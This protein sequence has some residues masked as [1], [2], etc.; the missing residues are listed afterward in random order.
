MKLLFWVHVGVL[1]IVLA[2]YLRAGTHPSVLTPSFHENATHILATLN[3]IT[4]S[5]YFR[6]FKT[7]SEKPCPYWAV[8]LLCSSENNCHVWKCNSDEVPR[9]LQSA[10]DMSDLNTPPTSKITQRFSHPSNADEW[11]SWINLDASDGSEYIDLVHNPEANTGYS[12]PQAADVWK[13]IYQE[14][15]L[16]LEENQGCKG[17]SLPRLLF[18]GLHTS[19]IIHVATNFYKD[20]YFSSPHLAAGLYNT[21]N[22]SYLP[23]CELFNSKIAPQKEFLQN[24]RLLSEFVFK[25][26]S[27]SEESFLSD[28]SVYNSGNDGTEREEDAELKANLMTLFSSP[29]IKT[30]IFDDHGFLD[31]LR[32]DSMEQ[33]HTMLS[34]VSTIMDCV[35]CEKCRV[36]GKLETKGLVTAMEVVSGAA[37]F[38][39]RAQRVTLVNLARQVYFSIRSVQ[40]MSV[41]CQTNTRE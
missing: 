15:C 24:L 21:P 17:A 19:I 6:Y 2:F 37:T 4:A 18:S 40:H 1:L 20:P 41:I 7:N 23:N 25:A 9:S 28:L 10:F 3:S 14:N 16:P 8:S 22:I 34:N 38:L 36:W 30:P 12:G 5:P 33:I 29:S 27:L 26:I 32:S 13:A 39:D 31:T 35:T 11:G